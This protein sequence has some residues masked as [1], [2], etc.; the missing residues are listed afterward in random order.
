MTEE[1]AELELLFKMFSDATRLKIFSV[2]SKKSCSVKDLSNILD[3]SQSA[4]SH[5]L[6]TLRKLNL[7]TF[8]KV[9][10]NVFYSLADDH[11]VTIFSQA[12]D[13]IRE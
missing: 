4:I 5:Q 7:V 1:Y 12:L 11:V 3:M 2:L 9:G 8:K 13:H 6:S 10:L